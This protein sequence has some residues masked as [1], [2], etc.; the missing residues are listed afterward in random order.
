MNEKTKWNVEA[1]FVQ[2][3][4]CDYGCPCEFSAPPTRGFCEGMG[5]WRINRGNYGTISLS[6]LGLGFAARWPKAIH[7]GNGTVCILVDDRA[8]S[9]Q[10]AALLSIASGEAGGLPFEIISATFSKVLDPRF[11][12]FQFEMNGRNGRVQLGEFVTASFAPI[13]NPVTGDPESVRVAHGTGFIFKEAECVSAEE[14][15][16]NVGDLVFSWPGK[17]GFVTQ[18][19]YGN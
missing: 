1:D 19:K 3:C 10:S 9:S 12:R 6:G 2:A 4:N 11:V 13:K 17:A 14:M 18:V 8:D 15:R 16:V 5:A 7:E